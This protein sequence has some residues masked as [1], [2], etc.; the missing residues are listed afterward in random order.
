M[1]K[2]LL[3][4]FV[5]INYTISTQIQIKGIIIDGLTNETL[6]GAN[7]IIKETKHGITTILMENTTYYPL[8]LCSV[9]QI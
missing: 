1:K 4:T 5:L 3:L 9:R 8:F 7:V 6:I 2:L